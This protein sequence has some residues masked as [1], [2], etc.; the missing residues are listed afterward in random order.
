MTREAPTQSS[1]SGDTPACG[2]LLRRL[3]TGGAWLLA[4]LVV[5]TLTV[6]MASAQD[7]SMRLPDVFKNTTSPGKSSFP[8]SK[9]GMLGPRPKI[10]RA[11]PI[12]LQTDR[13]VY[14][15][16][17]NRVIAEG[18]VEIYYNNYILT[19]DK[20][21]Y[22]QSLNKLMAEG[23]AQLKDPNGSVTRAD[24]F[25]ATDDFR[26]AFIQSLSVVAMD[27]CLLYTSDAADE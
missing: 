3:R 24:R 17:N 12:Y 13:L 11:Q 14:D 18:N 4:A 19:A 10:D 5:G 21:I 2:R 1:V 9:D 8:K 6:Q 27:D 16:K 22:D 25:E 23:N 7:P 26:D 15:E 20:V